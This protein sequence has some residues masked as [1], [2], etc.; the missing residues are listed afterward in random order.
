MANSSSAASETS[1]ASSASD[2]ASSLALVANKYPLFHSSSQTSSIK[3]NRD[4]YLVW[5]SIVMP[6]SEGN[7]LDSHLAPNSS[8]P[9]R[10]VSC[11]GKMV[12]NPA[13]DEW[14]SADKLL[15]GW[16]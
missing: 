9:A 10:L 1:A 12:P 8:P 5:E 2:S 4:N 3:L 16:L 14:V 7:L 11:N 13:Y 15:V 6:L